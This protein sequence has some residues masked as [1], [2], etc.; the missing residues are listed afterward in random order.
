MEISYK[1]GYAYVDG[2]KFRE[3]TDTGYYLSTKKI[4]SSRKRLHVYMWVKYNG[5]VPKGYQIHHKDEDKNNNEIENL[6]CMTKKEHLKWHSEN[7]SPELAKKQ[8]ANLEK[9]RAKAPDW[10]KSK[11]GLAWHKKQAENRKGK[12]FEEKFE[13]ECEYC[14]VVFKSKLQRTRFC[15]PNCRTQYRRISGVDNIERKCVVCGN[16]FT[17]NKYTKIKTCSDDCRI[18]AM[19]D[20]KRAMK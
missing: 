17:T 20:T 9:A 18:Q 10:H 16:P 4:G 12:R 15:S 11:E 1:D 3:D 6:I 19:K 14:K 13:K 7:I 8:M 2:Y 5:E